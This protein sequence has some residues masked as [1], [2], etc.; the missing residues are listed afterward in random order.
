[1]KKITLFLFTVFLSLNASAQYRWFPVGDTLNASVRTILTDSASS[2][3]IGGTFTKVGTANV[4]GIAHWT[5][6]AWNQ[7]AGSGT[8]GSVHALAHFDNGLVAAGT[9]SSIDSVICNNIA[10]YDGSSWTPLGNGLDY[11]GGITVSTLA[12]FENELYVGGTFITSNGDT[13]NNI[14]KW[15]GSGWEALGSGIN[16]PVTSICEYH[17]QIYAGGTFTSAGGEPV[18]NIARWDGSNWSDV[19]GGAGYTGGVTVSTMQVYNNELYIGGT[20]ELVNGDSIANI[21]RWNDT[22]WNPLGQG[23]RYTGGITVSTITFHE[24][25][26]RL[27]V[28]GKYILSNNNNVAYMLQSWDGTNWSL[29]NSRSSQPVYAV[30][31]VSSTLFIG[32][33]FRSIGTNQC[34]NYLAAWIYTPGKMHTLL[35]ESQQPE[36]RLFTLY[37]NP[38]S[39]KVYMK[40]L[41]ENEMSS[42]EFTFTLTDII[43]REVSSV[44]ILGSDLKFERAGIPAGIY[45]YNLKNNSKGVFQKG[46]V[47]FN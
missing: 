27:I 40:L 10:Y 45:Y 43:G 18:N 25:D 5:G 31:D 41:N 15:N 28:S 42:D 6:T 38:V 9:F 47:V 44:T 26:K 33:A 21:A 17:G 14:A 32:G 4:S 1:M 36:Q 23:M 19:G 16:G 11:T 7:V 24:V 35:T 30:A 39:D 22:V 3:Y 13:L 29:L 8:V 2:F 34:V 20:F 37:P 46:K 12:V